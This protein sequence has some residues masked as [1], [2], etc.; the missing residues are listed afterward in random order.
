MIKK[1]KKIPLL[2]IVLFS[3]FI[4]STSNLTAATL[5]VCAS[6][7]DHTTI[8]A[9]INAASNDDTIEI[10]AGTYLEQL[11][12]NKNLT[13]IGNSKENTIIQSPDVLTNRAWNSSSRPIIGIDT[14]TVH[15]SHL[16]ID[17]LKKAG[18]NANMMGIH[19]WKSSGS[20]KNCRVTGIRAN[21]LGGGQKVVAI[22]V[23]HPWDTTYDHSVDLENNVIDD[24]Q[25]GGIVVTEPGAKANII[26]NIITGYGPTGAIAQN[27]IQI[28]YGVGIPYN[29]IIENNLISG[30]YY[31][32]AETTATAILFVGVENIT[33]KNNN[34][35]NNQIGIFLSKDPYTVAGYSCSQ[36]PTKNIIIEANQINY[37]DTG[38]SNRLGCSFT[39]AHNNSFAHTTNYAIHLEDEEITLPAPKNWWGVNTASQ[40][41]AKNYG[42]L[43]YEPWWMNEDMNI[44]T[45][46]SEADLNSALADDDI[47]GVH[48]LNS[49]TLSQA[50]TL[51][52]PFTLDL[53]QHELITKGI[54][55]NAN[56]ITIKNGTINT[57]AGQG[58]KEENINA[59][60]L[61]QANSY[62]NLNNV[63]L[64]YQ[65]S[66]VLQGIYTKNNALGAN[67]TNSK[68]NIIHTS[69]N[70]NSLHQA[71]GGYFAAGNIIALNN[72]FNHTQAQMTHGLSFNQ[73]ATISQ[74][75]NL[76]DNQFHSRLI[77]IQA[78]TLNTNLNETD[79]GFFLSNN[80]F[81]DELKTTDKAQIMIENV[82]YPQLVTKAINDNQVTIDNAHEEVAITIPSHNS[83]ALVNISSFIS[84]G[85]GFTPPIKI[86]AENARNVKI[87]IPATNIIGNNNWTGTI[88]TPKITQITLP[89]EAGQTKTLSTAIT[90]GHP[91]GTL[92]FEKAVK[93]TFP[94]DS[95]KRVGVAKAGDTFNEI[96]TICAQNS[97]TWADTLPHNGECKINVGEDLIVWTKHFTTFATYSQL[98]V[99]FDDQVAAHNLTWNIKHLSPEMDKVLVRGRFL[100]NN[101][102][103]NTKLELSIPIIE[104]T[105]SQNITTSLT[106][107]TP[108]TFEI[109]ISDFN[110]GYSRHTFIGPQKF[111]LTNLDT[112]EENQMDLNLNFYFPIYN[113]NHK[114]QGYGY[115][116]YSSDIR[117][118]EAP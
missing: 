4:F 118:N 19:F 59:A 88:Q 44:I 13:L 45:A 9:A 33:I 20:V 41:E 89:T 16:T 61:I 116:I 18:S 94:G 104:K 65:D 62:L 112:S 82:T 53:N 14:A 17:G 100:A 97:Q 29:T 30:N 12:I 111:T 115:F 106:Q 74:P 31:S 25:K 35:N 10:G 23:N 96:T 32:N 102:I 51:N 110:A 67:L 60:I 113:Y 99:I 73:S 37:N 76:K 95:Y 48:L 24:Y 81:A 84:D 70:N 11:Y 87:E 3:L 21:P 79:I 63:E 92:S 58:V 39:S 42:Q 47:L 105:Y 1:S 77:G 28:G 93:I 5:T 83:E 26:N 117:L 72:I 7:C 66:Q 85:T 109:P 71:Y 2:I 98:G 75:Q 56:N 6:A 107:D 64:N 80:S 69:G 27:G 43:I 38:I 91:Q 36:C 50:L 34:I 52:R 108:F 114:T 101:P 57:S 46:T 15:L 90:L 8:Q 40:I 78:Q 68:F 22:W 54:N 103:Y 55:V 86:Q 49:I